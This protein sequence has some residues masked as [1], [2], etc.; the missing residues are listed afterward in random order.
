[1]ELVP[2]G[3]EFGV[4]VRGIG[5]IDVASS[6]AAYRS[7]RAVLEEHS[8]LLF[9][10]QEV[11][12]DVQAAFSRAFGPLERVK[13]GSVGAGTFYSRL[14]NI[15]ADGTPVP[16]THQQALTARANQLWHTDSSF[17]V[18]P[19]LASVLSARM[20]SPA[21]PTAVRVASDWS[22]F[23]MALAI[24][25]VAMAVGAAIY[26]FMVGAPITDADLLA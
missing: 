1:M 2:L 25:G 9:R 11:T 4:E 15:A 21:Y 20:E 17:K 10:E 13:I 22:S 14:H 23:V 7:I 8:V 3:P 18:T 12:D 6:D 16:D 26:Y 5:L 24:G 19:A